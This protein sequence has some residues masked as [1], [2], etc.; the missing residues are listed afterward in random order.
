[1]RSILILRSRPQPQ[2]SLKS[3]KESV[4]LADSFGQRGNL[5]VARFDLRIFH[6]DLAAQ[7]FILIFEMRD[8]AGRVR[9]AIDSSITPPSEVIRPP[10]N[11]AVISLPWTAGNENSGI[12]SSI[13]AAV[14]GA[15]VREGLA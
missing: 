11:A 2:Q 7:K 13:M 4:A 5:L 6:T 3:E 1:L 12:V 15:K 10:S 14:A 9:S 8:I